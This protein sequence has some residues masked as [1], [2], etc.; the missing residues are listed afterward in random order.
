[1]PEREGRKTADEPELP[2]DLRARLDA[3]GIAE[4]DEVALRR[5]L[6]RH[7]PGY[8]LFRL[9]PAAAKRWKCHYRI[10]LAAG[11]YDGQT[12]ADTYARALLA[13]LE[14]REGAQRPQRV[15]ETADEEGRF[16]TEDAEER[17]TTEGTEEEN[18]GNREDS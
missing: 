17:E 5:A 13:A 15:A 18:G 16:T 10:L 8:N 11:Y 14:E 6:E 7:V 2:D 4:H 1:M 9:T 3:A 12:A